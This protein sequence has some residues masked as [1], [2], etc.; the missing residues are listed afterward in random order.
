MGL[1][2]SSPQYEAPRGEKGVRSIDVEEFKRREVSV[3]VAGRARAGKSTALNNIF[4]LTLEARVSSVSVT[5]EVSITRII[6]NDVILNIIDTPGLGALD[7]KTEDILSGMS[8]LKISKQFILLYCTSV[9][10]NSSLTETDC[11]IVKNIQSIFGKRVWNRCVLLLTSSDTVRESDFLSNEHIVEYIAYLRGH[12][13]QFHQIL[14]GCGAAIPGAMLLFDYQRKQYA[15][16]IS[17][18]LVAIPVAK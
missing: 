12:A 18:K 1:I 16:T 2:W 7:I 3:I 11:T 5:K 14:K 10:P 8:K 4:G 9:A 17:D 15:D 6:Q 13:D